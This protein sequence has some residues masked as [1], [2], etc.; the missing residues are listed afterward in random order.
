MK[1]VRRVR[2]VVLLQDLEFGGTQ[3]YAL[4]LL[5]YLDREKFAAELWL[6]RGGLDLMPDAS[7]AG[8]EVVQLSNARRA[9]PL[10]LVRLGWRLWRRRPDL[11]YT[12][13]G[14]PNIWGRLFAGVL[15]I[16]VVTGYRSLH[17][18]QGERWLHYLSNRIIAD[19]SAL[20]EVMVTRFGVDSER[21]AVIPNAVDAEF[22]T[23]D[24][25]AQSPEPL[26]VCVARSVAEEDFPTLLEAFRLVQRE[27][28]DACLDIVGAGPL[29]LP[30]VA[31]IRLLPP[32]NDVRPYLRRAKVFVL[33]SASE[34]SSNAITEAMACGLPVVAPRAGGVPELVIHAET[35][36]LVPPG[37]P[38]ALAAALVSL[39][40]DEPRC[41]ALG[42]AGRERG[43][44]MF[45][46]PEMMRRSEA[47]FLEVAQCGTG[48]TST[49]EGD[50]PLQVPLWPSVGTDVAKETIVE[51]GK[52]RPDRSIRR[53]VAPSITIF[54]PQPDNATGMAVLICPGGGYAGVTIDKEGYE[55]ARW[56]AAAGITGIVVKYRLPTPASTRERLPLPLADFVRALHLVCER[57][58]EWH[59]DPTR[60]G[61]MGFSA[62]GHVA[63]WAACTEPEALAFAVLVYPVISMER[64]IT[65]LPSRKRFLGRDPDALLVARYSLEHHPTPCTPAIFLVHARDDDVV[66]VANSI[67]FADA[68]KKTG[69][70]PDM[71]LLERGGHGFGVGSRDAATAG[72]SDQCL[73]WLDNLRFHH[74]P[75]P[76]P[77]CDHARDRMS[78]K[79]PAGTP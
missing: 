12:L 5:K 41:E 61:A 15:R 47:I 62:G 21:I 59:I 43:S 65:H 39:L 4:Q 51:R 17:P 68:L 10:S 70:R 77:A 46:I 19:A 1:N 69:T 75:R 66:D 71:L 72:W 31:K 34:A 25:T 3:R 20:K 58:A 13:T 33:A 60:I 30:S 8:I 63:A 53:V 24:R 37:D 6:L 44:A 29:A 42:A 38:A 48:W 50:I 64:G 56:L 26:I 2:L 32:V 28:P 45:S 9:G 36:L 11:L 18:K 76:S 74:A 78:Q 23:P 57:A 35:G 79:R 7:A 54:P 55:V 73:A 16:P 40:R 67:R 22:F 14:V 49:S 27:V 52:F